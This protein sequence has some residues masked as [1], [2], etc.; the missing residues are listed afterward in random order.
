MNAE[1]RR[2]SHPFIPSFE[3]HLYN[4]AEIGVYAKAIY[5]ATN[6][7]NYRINETFRTPVLRPQESSRPGQ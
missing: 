7:A 4:A 6:L 5:D 2:T 1:A 3:L